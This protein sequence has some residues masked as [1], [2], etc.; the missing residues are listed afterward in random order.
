MDVP[1]HRTL[2]LAPWADPRTRRLPGTQP[3]DMADWLA[4]DEV[5]AAQMAERDRLIATR[6]GEVHAVLPQA[7]AAAAEVY[8][9]ILPRLPVLGFR[10]GAAE[11]LRPDGVTVPL[12][13]ARPLLTL[14]RLIQED[15][16]LMVEDGAGEHMLAGAILCF[17]AGWQLAQKLGRPL[18][19]IH[20]PVAAYTEDVGR[21][22]QRLMDAIRP[23]TPMWRMNANLSRAPLFNARS[24]DEPR[25]ADRT[26]YPFLRCERQCMIRLPVSRAVVF[27]IHTYVVRR[28]DLSEADE[29]ALAENPIHGMI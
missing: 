6:A 25:A 3:L 14:G 5:Y 9:M 2:P 29:R 15:V 27:T 23:E 26:A 13:P 21:R 28:E 10:L 12:D 7:T 1:L 22:V 11:A 18:M 8:S 17:P 19:R 16:C 24:E 20:R 4:V